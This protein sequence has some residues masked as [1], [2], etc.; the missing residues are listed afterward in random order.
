MTRRYLEL[1]REVASRDELE[2]LTL[3]S[4]HRAVFDGDVD[5]GSLMCGQVAGL[6]REVKP[7]REIFEDLMG[8]CDAV[9]RG[10]G[11]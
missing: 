7:L 2:A 9:I 8:G 6:V 4:L 11:E 3:G 1:E 5:G 10:L